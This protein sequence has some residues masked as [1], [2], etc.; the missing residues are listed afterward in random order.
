MSVRLLHSVPP[1]R[2]QGFIEILHLTFHLTSHIK[3][4]K[5]IQLLIKTNKM[6]PYVGN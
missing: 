6:D 1:K 3:D 2:G 5:E 4:L